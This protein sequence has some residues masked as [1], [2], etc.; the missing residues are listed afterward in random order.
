MLKGFSVPLTPEGNSAL[1][2]PP[3][4]RYSNECGAIEYWIDSEAIAAL[5]ALAMG[6][7]AL[8]PVAR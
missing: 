6:L 7:T 8:L 5:L 1:A 4:W 3:P 2:A